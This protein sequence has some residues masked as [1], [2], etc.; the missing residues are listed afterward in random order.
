MVTVFCKRKWVSRKYTGNQLDT[1]ETKSYDG[2]RAKAAMLYLFKADNL[3]DVTNKSFLNDFNE[4]VKEEEK[5]EAAKTEAPK[6]SRHEIVLDNEEDINDRNYGNSD[7]MAGD[8]MHGTHVSGIIGAERNNGKGI[9]GIADNVRIMMIRAVPNGDEHD[10]DV[11][12]SIR[13]AVDNGAK[14]VNMSFGKHFSPH[15]K[16]VDDAVKYAESKGVLLVEAAGNDNENAD[17]IEDF[18]NPIYKDSK[19][20]AS[21]WIT[22][23]ASSDP[24]ADRRFNSYTAY[25]SN[26]GKNRVDVFAPGVQIYSTLPGGNQYGSLSGTSMASPVVTGIAALI[27]EYFPNL[28]AQQ[29]KFCIEKSAVDPPFK[30]RKPGSENEMVDMKD[31]CRSGGIANAYGAV[32]LA[33]LLS[34]ENK[35]KE[36]LPKSRLENKKEIN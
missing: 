19:E 26:Y 15:K 20:R 18:P 31:L 6:D 4:L 21:N 32:K 23:G 33:Y 14:V 28:T 27:L 29:I 9:D 22:V 13:Y 3:M 25:F 17:S 10:K 11:A 36:V 24:L 5:K 34:E 1:F 12:L 7:V 16:W 30:V 8:P 35:K 2:K